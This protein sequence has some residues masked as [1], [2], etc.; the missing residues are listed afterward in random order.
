MPIPANYIAAAEAVQRAAASAP[1]AQVRL[2]AGPGTGKSSAIERR[3]CWLLEHGV[4]SDE[5]CGVSFTR[6]SARDL[7]ERIIDY[8]QSH[9]QENAGQVRVSTLH[10]LA[11]RMLSA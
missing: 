4:A 1:E 5:I 10:S 9:E 11:L 8:C 7:Q 6:A 3:V 2:I